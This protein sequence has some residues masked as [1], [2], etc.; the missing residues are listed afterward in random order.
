MCVPPVHRRRGAAEDCPVG[1]DQE[2]LDGCREGL[3]ETG[4]HVVGTR[5]LAIGLVQGGLQVLHG[6]LLDLGP[7]PF[8]DPGHLAAE[9]RLEAGEVHQAFVI[10]FPPESA[11]R[12][13]H[14]VGLCE[15]RL[16]VGDPHVPGARRARGLYLYGPPHSFPPLGDIMGVAAPEIFDGALAVSRQE[17][18]QVPDVLF[19]GGC[20]PFQL[21]L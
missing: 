12:E 17:R 18:A 4:L 14:V 21:L 13:H 11:N 5:G 2:P 16:G 7:G 19:E 15:E 20:L 8:R 1:V 6:V 10:Q 3:D 9:D